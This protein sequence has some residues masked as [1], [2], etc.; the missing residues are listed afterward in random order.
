LSVPRD[1]TAIERHHFVF[2]T[3]FY[4]LVSPEKDFDLEILFNDLAHMQMNALIDK[5]LEL[6]IESNMANAI[7]Q[8]VEGTIKAKR[9]GVKNDGVYARL[10][11]K[12]PRPGEHILFTQGVRLLPTKKAV[13]LFTLFSDDKDD[14]ILNKVLNIVESASVED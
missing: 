1:W 3:T 7:P 10:T 14:A 9:F 12:T 2:G 13:I 5:D 11:D 8:S 4:R 6:Y